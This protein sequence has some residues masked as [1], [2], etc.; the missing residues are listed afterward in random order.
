MNIESL[1]IIMHNLLK[2]PCLNIYIHLFIYS[3][4]TKWYIFHFYRR[5]S[6]R[7]AIT[8]SKTSALDLLGCQQ[9]VCKISFLMDFHSSRVLPN[10]LMQN[11]KLNRILVVNVKNSLKSEFRRGGLLK[12]LRLIYIVDYVIFR[13]LLKFNHFYRIDS[14]FNA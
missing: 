10:G 2:C 7:C 13:K 1:P 5:T 12:P 9:L 6:N 14:K 4:L 3:D 8:S 11:L